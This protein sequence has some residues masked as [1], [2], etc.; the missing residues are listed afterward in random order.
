MQFSNKLNAKF[1]IILISPIFFDQRVASKAFLPRIFAAQTPS[2]EPVLTL[3]RLTARS[4][5][6]I[7]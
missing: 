7:A 1:I 3:A 4:S 5:A 6:D 2:M